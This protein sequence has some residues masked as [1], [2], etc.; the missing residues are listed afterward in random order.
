MV[1]Q[2]WKVVNRFEL[3]RGQKPYRK[4]ATFSW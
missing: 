3:I 2:T 1:P 4:P